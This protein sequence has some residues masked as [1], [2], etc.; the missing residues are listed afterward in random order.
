M[1]YSDLVETYGDVPYYDHVVADTDLDGL[2]KP[3][4][5]RDEVMDAVYDDLVYA[6]E[7]VRVNDGAMNVNRDIV[8][9]FIT[10]IALSEASWQKYYYKNNSRAQKF[11]NLA[12]LAGDYVMGKSY[13]IVSEFRSLFISENLAGNKDVLLYR[14][15]DQA[16][17]ITHCVAS[18][19]NLSESVNF[20]LLPA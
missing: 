18:Y 11:F 9:G 10:R 6:F 15:Y 12:I 2:Y 1:R 4:T 14:H 17:G 16:V 8:A 7:N 13:D 3:R 20:G 19:N 5:P